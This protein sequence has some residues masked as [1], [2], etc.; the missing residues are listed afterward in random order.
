MQPHINGC[1]GLHLRLPEQLAVVQVSL[2]EDDLRLRKL[3]VQ[4]RVDGLHVSVLDG[5]GP[6]T[7]V[8]DDPLLGLE[9]PAPPD[10]DGPEGVVVVG[11]ES[12]DH[13]VEVVHCDVGDEPTEGL[14]VEADGLGQSSRYEEVGQAEVTE[15]FV[16]TVVEDDI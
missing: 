13:P 14:H 3:L 5:E 15:H 7:V 11:G 10:A 16:A 1:G 9:V 6:E 4:V 2:E 12:G 8:H